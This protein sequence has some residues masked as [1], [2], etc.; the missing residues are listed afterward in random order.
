MTK[1]T[2]N[3]QPINPLIKCLF[4][5]FDC[6][7]NFLCSKS[8]NWKLKKNINKLQ[9]LLAISGKSN[10]NGSES[11]SG[12]R[13][14]TIMVTGNHNFISE[15]FRDGTKLTKWRINKTTSLSFIFEGKNLHQCQISKE[16]KYVKV[17]TCS[18]TLQQPGH[19]MIQH[20]IWWWGR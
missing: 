17:D 15:S 19:T 8:K 11:L 12:S 4:S 10:N 14:K 9:G 6:G 3:R 18:S 5:S 7:D 16:I 13:E 2:P 1:K 20:Q